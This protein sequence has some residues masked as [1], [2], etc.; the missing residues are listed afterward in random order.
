MFE[1]PETKEAAFG[2]KKALIVS[3]SWTFGFGDIEIYVLH[4]E[5]LFRISYFDIAEIKGIDK[6][7]RFFKFFLL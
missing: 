5:N 7:K 3:E 2:G 1:V 4:K 6:K